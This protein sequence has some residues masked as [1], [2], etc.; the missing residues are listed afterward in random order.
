MLLEFAL[1]DRFRVHDLKTRVGASIAAID[2]HAKEKTREETKASNKKNTTASPVYL[3][4]NSLQP[5]VQDV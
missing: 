4:N 2:T 5:F 3:V 1:D